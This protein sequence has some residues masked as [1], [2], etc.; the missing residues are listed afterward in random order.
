MQFSPRVAVLAESR[1]SS[2]K[3]MTALS[4]ALGMLFLA[5]SSL[6]AADHSAIGTL[7]RPRVSHQALRQTVAPI[8]GASTSKFCYYSGGP[9]GT[10]WVCR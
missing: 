5:M 1:E 9:K 8:T 7:Q 10:S 3:E 4:S 2:M 6:E